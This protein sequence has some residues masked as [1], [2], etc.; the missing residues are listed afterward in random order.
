MIWLLVLAT[1]LFLVTVHEAG[2]FLAAKLLGMAVEEFAIGFGPVV[3]SRRRGETRYSL[4][5]FPIGGFVRLAG[6]EG[7]TQGV[8]FERTYYGRP[9]WVRLFVSLAGPVANILLAALIAVGALMGF[10]LPRLQVAGVVPEKPAEKALKLGDVVLK[11][12]GREVWL[13]DEVGPAIQA[14]S[15]GPVPFDIIR[16]GERLRVEITPEWDPT[17]GR[18]LVG[19]YFSTQVFL[20]KLEGLEPGSPLHQVGLRPGDVI[21]G[22]CGHGVGSLAELYGELEDGCRSLSV[23]RGGERLEVALPSLDPDA[24]LSGASFAGLP[25]VVERPGPGAAIWL[26]ARQVAQFFL[27]LGQFLGGLVRGSIPAGQAVSG[28]V[29]LAGLLSQGLQAGGL[30]TFLLIAFISLN[31]AAFNLLPIPALDGARMCFAL[32]ELMTRRRVSPAVEA[33]IH[34][35]GFLLL[36]GLMLLVTWRDIMRLVG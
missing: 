3:F 2:H 14:S 26:A 7:T 25:Q 16:D 31:L 36:L 24:L 33:A 10:G 22:A 27:A 13:W 21:K 32:F 20:P 11:V 8:P 30:A 1:L 19:A 4:R 9:A 18:Y 5:A 23:S 15:P 12:G 28:P 34:A 6:E 35:L 17:E 29:G